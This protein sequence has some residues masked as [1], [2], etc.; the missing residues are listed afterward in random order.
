MHL[1]K[2]FALSAILTAA[3][4]AMAYAHSPE[5]SPETGNRNFQAVLRPPEGGPDE[6]FGVVK[7]RQPIDA[8]KIVYLDVR[9][10]GLL[11]NHSYLLQRAVDPSVDDDCTGTNWLTLGRLLEPRAIVTNDKGKGRAALSRDLAAVPT[12]TQLDIHFRVIEEGTAAVVLESFCFQ[13]TV[14]Q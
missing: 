4:A 5:W 10:Q 2:L 6:G 12:G 3:G 7:F 9:V 11:P 14:T 8:D 13:F 1:L